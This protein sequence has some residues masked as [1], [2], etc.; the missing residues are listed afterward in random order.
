LYRKKKKQT[1]KR[2]KGTPE[3]YFASRGNGLKESRKKSG[4]N[5]AS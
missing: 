2:G 4:E 5:A 1:S 3:P